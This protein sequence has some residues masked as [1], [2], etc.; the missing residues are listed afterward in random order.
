MISDVRQAARGSRL[1]R[2]KKSRLFSL[3]VLQAKKSHDKMKGHSVMNKGS[4]TF[5]PF[6]APPA[7]SA[8]GIWRRRGFVGLRGLVSR[9]GGH[10]QRWEALY[11]FQ[12]S[13]VLQR[14]QNYV[15]TREG[16]SWK[17][18]FFLKGHFS[19]TPGPYYDVRTE[20]PL[21][22]LHLPPCNAG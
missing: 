19:R 8:L 22:P 16:V 20:T 9:G 5:K 7:G 2:K 4:C 3:S 18:H 15:K 10:K 14:K 6:W 11:S 13:L 12:M 21:S 17:G 1:I